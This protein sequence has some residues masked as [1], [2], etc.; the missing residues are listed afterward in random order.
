MNLQI[1]WD[2]MPALYRETCEKMAEV[3]REFTQLFGGEKQ[4]ELC[5][6][7]VESRLPAVIPARDA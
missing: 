1:K 4:E 2:L 5:L 3:V 7:T 6:C